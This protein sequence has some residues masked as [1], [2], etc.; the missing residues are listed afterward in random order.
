MFNALCVSKVS[1]MIRQFRYHKSFFGALVFTAILAVGCEGPEKVDMGA[2]DRQYSQG[3]Y[4]QAYK[5][6]S[7]AVNSMDSGA[8]PLR[9]EAAYI[10]GLSASQLKDWSR[11]DRYLAIASRSSDKELSGK[12]L[13]QRGLVANKRGNYDAS[14]RYLSQAAGKLNGQDRANCYYHAA[15]AEQKL[16]RWPKSRTHLTMARSSSKDPAF[17]KRVDQQRKVSGYAIQLGAY[18]DRNNAQKYAKDQAVKLQGLSLRPTRI[19]V[20]SDRLYRV[21]VG[22]FKTQALAKNAAVRMGNDKPIIVPIVD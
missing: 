9:E 22:Q 6:A 20:T 7:N 10:A 1:F 19:V 2:I 5:M 18:R 12:A 15:V 13:A 8:G 14:A 21:Q 11:A 16:G 4:P 17:R 3:D